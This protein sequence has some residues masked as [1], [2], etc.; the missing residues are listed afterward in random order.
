MY[1]LSAGLYT[2]DTVK[3]SDLLTAYIFAPDF[4]Y[5]VSTDKICKVSTAECLE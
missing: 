3:P 5:G 2:A 4:S 1:R